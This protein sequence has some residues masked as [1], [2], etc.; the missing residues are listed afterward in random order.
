MTN[1][2]KPEEFF[3][4]GKTI[5]A[6]IDETFYRAHIASIKELGIHNPTIQ[7][8]GVSHCGRWYWIQA[9]P[10]RAGV[11]PKLQTKN[12]NILEGKEYAEALEKAKLSPAIAQTFAT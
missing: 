4:F 3:D 2:R 5:Q 6:E 7:I 11:L 8:K 9:N 10:F 12:I 1:P